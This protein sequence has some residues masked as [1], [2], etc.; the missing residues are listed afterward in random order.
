MIARQWDNRPGA[1]GIN[2]SCKERHHPGKLR[3][4]LDAGRKTAFGMT[5]PPVFFRDRRAAPRIHG[6]LPVR[7]RGVTA[8]SEVFETHTLA[9]NLSPGGLYLQL[10]RALLPG[11]K[12]FTVTRLPGGVVV[13]ARGAVV[14][15][16]SKP[17]GL[18]GV[19]VRFTRTRLL[20]GMPVWFHS[21]RFPAGKKQR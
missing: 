19:A 10:P 9:D 2:A 6:A 21:A 20:P 7:V 16:E 15:T 8:S 14:R 3:D 18:S 12:L 5:N 4:R 1:V 11:C 17:H 13:A